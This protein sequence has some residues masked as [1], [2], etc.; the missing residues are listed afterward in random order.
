MIDNAFAIPPQFIMIF[1]GLMVFLVKE[2]LRTGFVLLI[3]ALSVSAV[4]FLPETYGIS[5]T[6]LAQDLV[7]MKM[8]SLGRIFSLIF[9]LITFFALVFASANPDRLHYSAGLVYAGAAVGVV[10]SGDFFSMYAFWEIMAVAS[11]FL[12]LAGNTEK[13][14]KAAF[15]YI[16]VHITGGLILLAGIVLY[17]RHT[18][19]PV[20]S[21]LLSLS[22]PHGILIFLGIAVNCAM[23]P[24]HG[25]LKD[26][27]PEASAAGAV[28]LSAFTTK[29][30]VC[31][32]AKLYA[33][34]TL[35][36]WMGLLMAVYPL[37]YALIEKDIRRILAYCII[38]QVGV[39]L[40][41]VGIGTEMAI[42]GVAT[43]GFSHILYK[44]LLFMAAGSV[45]TA[46]GTVCISEQTKSPGNSGDDSRKM[47]CRQMPFTCA[48]AIIGGA[49]VSLPFF[50]GFISK[51]MIASA[52]SHNHM[53][54]VWMLLEFASAGAFLAAGVRVVF[55]LF[56]RENG[57]QTAR[58]LPFAMKAAMA[59]V[60]LLCILVGLFPKVLYSFA[61]FPVLYEPYT[62]AHIVGHLELLLFAV[63]AYMFSFS[64]GFH[65]KPI[66]KP[67]PDLDG[68]Y[69]A[70]FSYINRELDMILNLL[71]QK[72][73]SFFAR[74]FP[75]WVLLGAKQLPAK[76]GVYTIVVN[77]TFSQ[78]KKQDLVKEGM[79]V[80][81]IFETATFPT[82]LCVVF[83]AFFVV[84][85]FL[86]H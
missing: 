82:G 43:H 78:A 11:T 32:M 65:P 26:A 50:C 84:V 2:R 36:I 39:M 75:K 64:S 81:K 17:V 5:A 10:F 85:L 70:A 59:G 79:V 29:S 16:L 30:A 40:C 52:A 56:F 54:L 72:A 37:V 24:M 69:I 41:G 6:F 47:L 20:F 73:E 60:A 8:D 13:A 53:I 68:V 57:M 42:N 33:G 67:L 61:P 86:M 28:F 44:A 4:L 77:K 1:G 9:T 15:R 45:L 19:T 83:A 3:S 80:E 31:M 46:A 7:I 23:V 38:N 74:W 51:S 25:W 63:L 66:Q 35:L 22:T 48:M 34:T 55:F 14:Y 71:N 58:D 76:I 27:Y 49:S 21:G 62:P 18:G 12:I